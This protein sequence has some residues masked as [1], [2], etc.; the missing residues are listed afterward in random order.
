MKNRNYKI[1]MVAEKYHHCFLAAEL[2]PQRRS[3]VVRDAGRN[4]RQIHFCCFPFTYF[5]MHYRC[6]SNFLRWEGLQV[7]FREEPF[8]SRKDRLSIFPMSNVDYGSVCLGD[9]IHSTV[10]RGHRKLVDTMVS[11]FFSTAFETDSCHICF[12]DGSLPIR[13]FTEWAEWTR[14]EPYIWRDFAYNNSCRIDDSSYAR[15]RACV[16]RASD[17][18]GERMR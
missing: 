14:I 2:P 7:F 3:L 10:F 6:E 5:I 17:Y 16:N 11:A 9:A 13:S 8:R 12:K 4:Y 15:V 1:V 18:Q